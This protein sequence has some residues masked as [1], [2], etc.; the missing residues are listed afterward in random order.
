M[1]KNCKS[2]V[3]IIGLTVILGII[4]PSLVRAGGNSSIGEILLS[5]QPIQKPD[6]GGMF[7]G[8]N[9]Y[10]MED[11]N[12]KLNKEGLKPI[13]S[14]VDFAIEGYYDLPPKNSLYKQFQAIWGTEYLSAGTKET[15]DSTIVKWTLP[16]LG[17]YFGSQY[18]CTDS[19]DVYVRLQL[20]EY[21]LF[22]EKANLKVTDRPGYLEVTGKT[23]GGMI[24]MGWTEEPFDIS[25]SYRLLNFTTATQEE[26]DGFI[27]RVSGQPI[28]RGPL[29]NDLDY[30]GFIFKIGLRF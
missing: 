13:A 24:G 5:I 10:D 27:D 14:G 19:K 23:F 1:K 16:I 21:F 15:F 18:Y 8:L 25:V 28:P 20:G 4:S 9:T 7:I 17:A 11:F 30:S 3:I 6:G 2:Q 12:D 29:P 22:L 26:K